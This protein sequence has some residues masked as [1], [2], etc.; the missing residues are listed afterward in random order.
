MGL[1][2]AACWRR[3]DMR[4]FVVLGGLS[5][6]L[7]LGSYGGLYEV[8][9]S[10]M[11]L[12][13][14]FRYP[15]KLMGIATFAVTMLAAGGVDVIRRDLHES[16][17][18]YAAGVVC[19]ALAAI[20]GTEGG[21]RILSAAWLVPSDLAEHIARTMTRSALYAAAGALAMGGLLGWLRRRPSE[22]VWAV[23]LVLLLAMDLARANLPVVQTSSSEAWTFTPGLVSALASDA[24]VTGPGHF[25]IL[26]IKDSTANVSEAVEKGLTSRERIA[27]IRRHGMYLEHNAVFHIESVQHY[28]AGVNPRVDQIGGKGN[29]RLAARYNVAYLIGRPARFQTESFAGSMV[30]TLP[31]YDLALVR[32]PVRPTPR[33]YLSQ[34]PEPLSPIAP[35]TSLLERD[36]F[37]NGEVD[38]IE[39]TGIPLPASQPGSRATIVD[40]RPEMVRVDIETPQAA[41]LVLG[42]AFEP[43]WT[44]RIDGGDALQ[45]F[46]A[47]GL[48][49]AVMVP[50]GRSLVLFEYETPGLRFGAWVTAVGLLIAL[51]LLTSCRNLRTVSDRSFLY[52][53]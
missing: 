45:I 11:P 48:V 12:W 8:L 23:G 24:N 16:I 19:L 20:L 36:D 38:G 1:A 51:M 22:W 15:E 42:D 52:Q 18:W 50:A 47:N 53:N 4:V 6:L 2:M 28:L 27:A 31:A 5:L 33:A 29:L 25:R 9:Y 34:R 30:A 32:N 40:Y 46:R 39:S 43:G 44:A 21:A 13:S 17:L 10:S 3:R 49:R 41:V 35:I 14:A 26:S 37:L 7:A